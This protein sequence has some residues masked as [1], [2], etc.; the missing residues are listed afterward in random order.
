MFLYV[1]IGLFNRWQYPRIPFPGFDHIH[2]QWYS[3]L[4]PGYFWRVSGESI[5]QQYGTPCICGQTKKSNQKSKKILLIMNCVD[6]A[7]ILYPL[8]RLFSSDCTCRCV[9]FFM[10][11]LNMIK[12]GGVI[13]TE[14]RLLTDQSGLTIPVLTKGVETNK[15]PIN[16]VRIDR[17]KKWVNKHIN[18]ITTQLQQSPFF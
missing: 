7:T 16:E 4:Y 10:M 1:M 5:R 13:E 2:I 18:A 12:M 6:P 11:M 15:I 17:S 3:T 14:S 9:L 8:A